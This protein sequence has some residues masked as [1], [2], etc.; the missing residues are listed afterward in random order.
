M[1]FWFVKN[2]SSLSNFILSAIPS[3]TAITFCAT[4]ERLS[5]KKY[6]NPLMNNVPK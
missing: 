5:Y 1:L 3:E 6:F 2:I 4:S